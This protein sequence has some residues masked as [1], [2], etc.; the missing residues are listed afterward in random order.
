MPTLEET[1]TRLTTLDMFEA[2]SPA[3]MEE[4]RRVE[5]ELGLAL[6][7]QYV[8][9]LKR[10]GSARSFGWQVFGTRPILTAASRPTTWTKDCVEITKTEKSSGSSRGT[11]FLPPAH[12]VISTDG[13]G[14]YVVLF[15]TGAPHEGE[16]H[17]YN[18]EDQTQPIRVWKTFQDYLESRIAEAMG[19]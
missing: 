11:D 2:G 6:P 9:F 1:F 10:F 5:A 19:A 8:G 17:Y 3:S 13:A 18:L 7:A 16:V 12:V 14:G 15:G 4:I